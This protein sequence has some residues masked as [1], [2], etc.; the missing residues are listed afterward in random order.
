MIFYLVRHCQSEGN[1]KG[2]E[3][4]L[5]FARGDN[6]SL[7][8]KGKN[9][10]KKLGD[11]FLD[12]KIKIDKI[13]VSPLKRTVQTAKILAEKLKIKEVIIDDNLIDIDLGHLEGKSYQEIQVLFKDFFYLYQK[14]R[15]NTPF[16]GGESKADVYQ[17]IN[18]FL[19][20]YHFSKN[21]SYLIVTHEGIIRIFLTFLN[22]EKG[23]FFEK[24][25]IFSIDN[26]SVTQIIFDGKNHPYI[27]GIGLQKP[28]NFPKNLLDDLFLYFKNQERPK[29][30]KLIPTFSDNFVFYCFFS[31]SEE[32][33]K[34]IPINKENQLKKDLAIHD[35]FVS[36]GIIKKSSQELKKEKKFFVIK[37][38]YNPL[39]SADKY[40]I[41]N[42]KK[43]K[44]VLFMGQSLRK[45]HTIGK[46]IKY[47]KQ[48]FSILERY[49][50]KEWKDIFLKKWIRKSFI[51]LEKIN[52]QKKDLIKKIVNYYYKKIDP[53][54][55]NEGLIYF[56]FYP[57]NFIV[58]EEKDSFYMVDFFDFE[59]AFWGD[60]YW[61]LA[62]SIKLTFY[63]NL[64]LIDL[65]LNS[66]FNNHLNQGKKEV[67]FFYLLLIVLGSISY[68]KNKKL[69]FLEEVKNLDYFLRSYLGFLKLN[70][71]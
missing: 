62:Y 4:N 64:N 25:D 28:L 69:D 16:P 23:S 8:E 58:R 35:F 3:N 17:R 67:I 34:F 60:L 1:V 10:V 42:L 71:E 66:Y 6:S 39:G 68:K 36:Q 54:K 12:K 11:S 9:Q 51:I 38:D 53:K 21:K 37:K 14:N 63:D 7:T 2:E 48:I 13:F 55:V 65:F 70:I 19:K 57:A 5:I 52:Y 45:I 30:F 50:Q 27:I 56:D 15:F 49:N 46:K 40:L 44:L 61:D 24:R 26:A 29:F 22:Q 43:E 20:K 59:N 33:L 18:F 32:I 31:N 41:D 47:N